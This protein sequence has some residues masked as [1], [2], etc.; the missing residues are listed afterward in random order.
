MKKN[1]FLTLIILAVFPC[2]AFA[3]SLSEI[4]NAPDEFDSKVVEIEGE[5]IGNP[6]NSPNGV[7]IN[8]KSGENNIGLFSPDKG[9]L[10][11]IE[12]WGSY[13]EKGDKL[14]IRGV[15]YK[16]CPLHQISG[17]HLNSLSIIER[18]SKNE[19]ALPQERVK[20]ALM[21]LII[22]LTTGLIYFIKRFL[23]KPKNP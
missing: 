9:V 17:I 13:R 4:L 18:G 11:K 6:L 7:W 23:E 15:F 14:K 16:N 1:I 5:A 21:L 8:I 3:A 12:H 10:E 20:L 19:V 22:C 2:F